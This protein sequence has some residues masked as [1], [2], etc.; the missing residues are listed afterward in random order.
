MGLVTDKE[1]EKAK[2]NFD[3][4]KQEYEFLFFLI[5]NSTFKGEDLEVL[6]KTSLKLQKQ[7]IEKYQS[8]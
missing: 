3:L 5:K 7:Y 4:L 8:K 6:Y 2:E 1:K